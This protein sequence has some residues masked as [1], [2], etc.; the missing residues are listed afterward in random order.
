MKAKWTQV[1]EKESNCKEIK[2]QRPKEASKE[3]HARKGRKQPASRKCRATRHSYWRNP[4]S[5]RKKKT[6][7]W[8][9]WK[10]CYTT[11]P[12]VPRHF[13]EKPTEL[14]AVYMDATKVVLHDILN[15]AKSCYTEFPATALRSL[16]I[17]AQT[18]GKKMPFT[19]S[20][21]IRLGFL[22]VISNFLSASGWEP[23]LGDF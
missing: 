16:Y 15:K 1:Q 23:Q 5:T 4:W 3:K 18:R 22:I 13:K 6:R 20:L 9:R 8:R 17:H 21:H 19:Y 11:F 12:G 7:R 2:V 10:S 14:N